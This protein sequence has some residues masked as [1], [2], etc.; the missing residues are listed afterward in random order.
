MAFMGLCYSD[1]KTCG[2]I[3]TNTLRP[4]SI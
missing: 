1:F 3:K 2:L 4:H